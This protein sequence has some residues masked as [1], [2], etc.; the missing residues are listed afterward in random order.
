MSETAI[1]GDGV[2]EVDDY[3]FIY[4]SAPDQSTKAAHGVVVC[5]GKKPVRAWKAS[6]LFK[7]V[8]NQRIMVR[9]GCK[10]IPITVITVYAPD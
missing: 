7:E 2:T 8:V 9:I 1:F 5:L 6:D 4:S 10:P 3:T